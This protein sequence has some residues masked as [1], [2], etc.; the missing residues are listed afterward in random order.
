[1]T[2]TDPIEDF[3]QVRA[4]D[5]EY[6]RMLQE[7]EAFWDS[8]D[9]TLLTHEPLPAVQAYLNE[10]WTGDPAKS[11][12]EA[13]G[14]KGPFTKACIF[15]AGPGEVEEHLLSRHADLQIDVLDISGEALSR[16]DRRVTR[17]KNRVR[18]R[19][20]DLNF[21]ELPANTYDL[22]IANASLH[23]LVNLEHVAFQANRALTAQGRFFIEDT[24]GES[25]FQFEDEKKQVY[26]SLIAATNDSSQPPASIDW[27]DRDNWQ[28]SPFESVRSAEILD[29]FETYLEPVEVRVAG[30]LL[31]L[32]LFVRRPQ[33]TWGPRSFLSSVY[34][35]LVAKPSAIARGIAHGELLFYLDSLTCDS[36]RLRPGQA[37]AEY[38][39]RAG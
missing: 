39:K 2:S 18:T 7:E 38:R 26:Q 13:V 32:T 33:R 23:H 17:F 29:V 3:L 27:P 9:E 37:F 36:G 30:S 19:Q 10:R 15:G 12:F 11:W 5:A 34:Y 24:V 1:M 35:D 20:Q 31:F 25:Y 6:V 8:H 14:E 22:I 16:L 4:D 21:V 28:F